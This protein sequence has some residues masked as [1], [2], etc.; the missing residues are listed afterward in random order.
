MLICGVFAGNILVMDTGAGLTC[1]S[2]S[3]QS[4]L[5]FSQFRTNNFENA[6]YS[7]TDN[8]HEPVILYNDPLVS[9]TEESITFATYSF[10]LGKSRLVAFAD[11]DHISVLE[12]S[13]MN[14]KW[15]IWGSGDLRTWFPLDIHRPSRDKIFVAIMKTGGTNIG[16]SVENSKK[17][18]VLFE[19][20]KLLTR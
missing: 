18:A 2:A 4:I 17:V 20:C 5:I 11:I 7:N 6:S 8:S 9:I 14:G 16:F 10:P 15:R 3:V 1:F 12:P 13:I 19:E